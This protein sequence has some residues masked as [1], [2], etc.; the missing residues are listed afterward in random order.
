VNKSELTNAEQCGRS[1]IQ[2][3]EAPFLRVIPVSPL[4]SLDGPPP[5]GDYVLNEEGDYILNEEWERAS[6][7]RKNNSRSSKSRA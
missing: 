7:I 1:G 4:N 5:P 3:L 2:G 6:A